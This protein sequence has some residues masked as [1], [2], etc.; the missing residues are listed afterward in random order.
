MKKSLR[1]PFTLIELLVVIAIIAILAAMLLPALSKARDKARAISCTNNMK[2]L[3]LAA[4]M[5]TDDEN[6]YLPCAGLGLAYMNHCWP[7]K[8]FPYVGVMCG[9]AGWYPQSASMFHCPSNITEIPAWLKA[10]NH[11]G[12][13]SYVCNAAVMDQF[14]VDGNVDGWKGHR[15]LDSIPRSSATILFAEAHIGG[16]GLRFSDQ[17]VKCYNKGFTWEYSRQNAAKADDSAKLGYHNSRNN[18]VFCDGHVESLRWEETFQGALW[19]KPNL[20]SFEK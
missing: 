14:H 19:Q 13:N 11:G 2:T 12:M 15:L 16:N 1:H 3:G 4:I 20:W 10:N 9:P 17:A 18:W 7:V 8:L 6:G 5:Y